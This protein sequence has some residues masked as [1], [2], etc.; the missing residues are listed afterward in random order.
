MTGREGI[1]GGEWRVNGRSEV[2]RREKERERGE[3]KG[4]GR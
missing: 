2:V 1:K 4:R 3:E